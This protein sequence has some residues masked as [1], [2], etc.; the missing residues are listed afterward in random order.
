MKK[1][2]L[3]LF[4]LYCVVG[5]NAQTDTAA[6]DSVYINPEQPPQ[7]P[8][9]P[10]MMEQFITTNMVYPNQ[11]VKE[12]IEGIVKV[13]FF[14]ETNGLLTDIEIKSRETGAGL[15]QEA[16]RI[17]KLMPRFKPGTYNG[18][19]VRMRMSIPIKFKLK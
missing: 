16:M 6:K 12:K 14:V 13:S 8:G 1:I 4:T 9:G 19:P 5:V 3:F 7:Y 15:E 2:I 10:I 18:K 11:A 17:V